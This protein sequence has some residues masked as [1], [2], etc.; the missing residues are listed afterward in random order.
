MLRILLGIV[1][2]GLLIS[3]LTCYFLEWEVKALTDVVWGGSADRIPFMDEEYKLLLR[4]DEGLKVIKREYPEFMLGTDWLGFAHVILAILF[5]GAIRDP[6]RNIL[7]IQFGII[8]AILVIPAA[9]LFGYLRG[10]PTIH[11][12]IDASFGI[13]A[14]IP[15]YISYRII[16]RCDY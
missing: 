12:F 14:L 7:I 10:L 6:V 11:Y 2:L 8:S 3:G 5:L 15:L 16:K 4:V 9:W 1:A 13:G